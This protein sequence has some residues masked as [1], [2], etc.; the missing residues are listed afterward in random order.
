MG[1]IKKFYH[2]VMEEMMNDPETKELWD[3]SR[4]MTDED[5]EVLFKA[6]HD[7]SVQ[8]MPIVEHNG[9]KYV[10][11]QNMFEIRSIDDYMIHISLH[12]LTRTEQNNL[13][14]QVDET[15][16]NKMERSHRRGEENSPHPF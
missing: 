9:N 13:K 12:H 10:Y 8:E 4:H 5:I 16:S 15:T 2:D 7:D 1:A 6:Y 3:K 11:D 14:S